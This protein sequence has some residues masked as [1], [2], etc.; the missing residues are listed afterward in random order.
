MCWQSRGSERR[1]SRR[2]VE[3]VENESSDWLARASGTGVALIRG[4]QFE[5]H[6]A[7]GPLGLV[8][9]SFL[10][11]MRRFSRFRT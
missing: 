6:P 8:R 1:G 4:S 7:D 10:L 9:L 2:K 11:I 5:I 3:V